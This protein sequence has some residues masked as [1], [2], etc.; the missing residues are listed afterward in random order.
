MLQQQHH[1]V[2]LYAYITALTFVPLLRNWTA[3]CTHTYTHTQSLQHA[4]SSSRQVS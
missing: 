2:S 4:L 3:A 1:H